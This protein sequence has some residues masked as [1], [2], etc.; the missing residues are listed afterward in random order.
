MNSTQSTDHISSPFVLI[1]L[2][3]SERCV[4][5]AVRDHPTQELWMLCAANRDARGKPFSKATLAKLKHYC[6]MLYR[7]T[8]KERLGEL[9]I[10][11]I[12]AVLMYLEERG[13]PSAKRAT[14]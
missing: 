9:E 5:T 14:R 1:D 3:E 12:S 8:Q 11:D 10:S 6:Q 7:V 13:P 4:D 2:P